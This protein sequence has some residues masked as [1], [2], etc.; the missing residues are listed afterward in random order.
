MPTE[1]M[2]S[3]GMK[4][5]LPMTNAVTLIMVLKPGQRLRLFM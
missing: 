4:E 2:G 3:I 1:T 5:D